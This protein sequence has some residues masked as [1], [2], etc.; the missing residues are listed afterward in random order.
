MIRF[1]LLMMT[2]AATPQD[3]TPETPFYGAIW[4]DLG[5][6]A[7]IGNGN[8]EGARW[9]N[10]GSEGVAD[11]HVRDLACQKSRTKTRCSFVL[12]RDGGVKQDASGSVPDTLHCQALFVRA[13]DG[14]LSVEHLP[15]L[16]RGGHS[17]TTM[18]CR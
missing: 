18:R 4:H 6:N 2:V 16:P 12:F 9:Y 10:A 8:M 3:S 5:V 13:N 11:L 17:R 1:L 7:M 15:P 14:D